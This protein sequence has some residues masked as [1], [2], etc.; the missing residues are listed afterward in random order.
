MKNRGHKGV[1]KGGAGMCTTHQL[2]EK[3]QGGI[4]SSRSAPPPGAAARGGIGLEEQAK[5]LPL[6][7]NFW[8]YIDDECDEWADIVSRYK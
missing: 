7:S 5:A 6:S 4:S 2:T 3:A 1:E 8:V